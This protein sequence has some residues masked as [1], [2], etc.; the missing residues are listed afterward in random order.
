VLLVAGQDLDDR[1]ALARNLGQL[2][3][4]AVTPL[5][6]QGLATFGDRLSPSEGLVGQIAAPAG[7]VLREGALT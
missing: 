5:S 1:D 4:A 2:F 7:L 3:E 6:L